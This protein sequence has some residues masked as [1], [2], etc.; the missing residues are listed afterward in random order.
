[1]KTRVRVLLGIFLTFFSVLS[2]SQSPVPFVN[3]PLVPDATAPGGAQFTLTVNG[4]GFVSNS[5]VNWNGDALVTQFV[6]GSQLAATVPA[7]DIAKASTASVTVVTPAPGGGT[8][9]A[10][11]FSVTAN[12]GNSVAFTLASSLPTGSNPQSEAVGDFNGDGKLDLAVGN[13]GSGTISIFLGDG[14]GHFTSSSL[15]VGANAAYV[16][17][18]DFNGDGKLD[19]A[20]GGDQAGNTISILLGDGTGHFHLVSS[21]S[22]ISDFVAVGDFNGDGK[23]DLAVLGSNAVSILLGDGTGNLNLASSAGVDF[24]PWGMAVGDFNGDGK[25]DLAVCNYGPNG[26]GSTVSILVG[27]GTGNFTRSSSPFV[28]YGPVLLAPGDFN[29]D[30]KLDFAVANYGTNRNGGAVSVLLG[31]GTGNFTLAS[32]PATGSDPMSVA[33]GDFNGDGKPDLVTPNQWSNN[34]SV[35]LGDGTGSFTL[36]SS[37]ASGS[38][39][40]FVAVGDFNGDGTLDLAA[41]NYYGNSVSILLGGPAP[42]AVSLSP[43]RLN[44]GTQV[45]GTSSSP[46]TV[47]LTNTGGSALAISKISASWNFAQTNNCGSSVPPNGHCVIHAAFTPHSAGGHMGAITITDNASTSPQTV[48]VSGV[49][50]AVSLSPPS[51]DFGSQPVGTTSQPQTVTLTNHATAALSIGKIQINTNFAQTNNCGT[52][53]AAGGSCTI[54]VTFTPTRKGSGTVPLAIYDNGGASPQIVLASGN[55]T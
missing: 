24:D 35:F 49:G 4:T 40:W 41:A 10:A 53:V 9:N 22:G 47:T 19:L 14:T 5:V 46:Q 32:S 1:M 48:S 26:S 25:L 55:G 27:D 8:S 2:Y 29:G 37:P 6:S 3:Q 12:T 17:T 34:L 20:V 45:I 11:F 43:A 33:V 44:F 15:K 7:A 18:G 42:P 36:A 31:D 23:L 16:V 30:S 13:F 51:L 28:G 21:T 39:P 52:S 38:G 50:T 54:S